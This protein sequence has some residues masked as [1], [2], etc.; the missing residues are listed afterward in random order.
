MSLCLSSKLQFMRSFFLISLS[1]RIPIL[2][3]IIDISESTDKWFFFIDSD[4]TDYFDPLFGDVTFIVFFD[5]G[6]L[7]VVVVV[8]AVDHFEVV[9]EDYLAGCQEVVLGLTHQLYL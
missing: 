5:Y 3:I 6:G 2:A 4:D 7:D 1:K 9:V 8:D